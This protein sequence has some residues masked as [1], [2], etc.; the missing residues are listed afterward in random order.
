MKMDFK[1]ILDDKSLSSKE[2][3]EAISLIIMSDKDAF[4]GLVVIAAKLK[5]PAKA[6][7]LEAMEYATKISPQL[8]EK[9]CFDFAVSSLS[10]KAPRVKWESARL[11]GNIAKFFIDDIGV[12]VKNLLD[13]SEHSGTVVR[14]SAAYALSEIIKCNNS[15]NAELIPAI[16]SICL[17]EEK[18]SIK[19]IYL[20]ALKKVKK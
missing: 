4:N 19:K 11:I 6:T 9:A 8:A 10:S 15:I 5:D 20:A 3:T 13:N 12:A 1:S 14:W 7:C 17:R 2:K 18:N 16:E